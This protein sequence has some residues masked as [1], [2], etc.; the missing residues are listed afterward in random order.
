MSLVGIGVLSG[1]CN[2]CCRK[3]SV[4]IS[5]NPSYPVRQT[6]IIC[7]LG[8]V[9]QSHY[10]RYSSLTLRTRP[11]PAGKPE[12]DV[13][14]ASSPILWSLLFSFCTCPGSPC[15]SS[16]LEDLISLPSGSWWTRPAATGEPWRLYC[17][18][19]ARAAHKWFFTGGFIFIFIILFINLFVS[20]FIFT[21]LFNYIYVYLFI[22]ICIILYYF[23]NSFVCWS[24]ISVSPHSIALKI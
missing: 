2:S 4:E 19:Y 24:S 10:K 15:S 21:S 18:F 5:V 17:V 11:A 1:V 14:Y 7:P 13:F 3:P 20:S 12:R 8:T 16:S 22:F 9:V 23:I 6:N